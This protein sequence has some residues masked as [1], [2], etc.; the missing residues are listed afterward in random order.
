M[1]PGRAPAVVALATAAVAVLGACGSGNDGPQQ[2]P[3]ST[4]PTFGVLPWG[5]D[6]HGFGDRKE[7]RCDGD[8]QAVR[9]VWKGDD[10]FL[11][12]RR[13]GPDGTGERYLRA[14]TIA[15]HEKDAE[16]KFYQGTFYTLTDTSLQ[17]MADGA[18]FDIG[19]D[20]VTIEWPKQPGSTTKRFSWIRTGPGWSR[21]D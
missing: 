18:K 2:A 13:P 7:I 3:V 21:M 9:M 15:G 1:T 4:P 11:I 12:C 5:A 6:L 20:T 17:F 19:Q 8:D 16:K 14:W 10:R